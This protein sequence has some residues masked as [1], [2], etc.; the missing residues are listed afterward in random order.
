MT[1]SHWSG[2]RE[3]TAARIALG[4]AGTSLPTPALLRFQ[5]DHAR[6]R[7]AV[8]GS[9]DWDD[10]ARRLSAPAAKRADSERADSERADP[11]RADSRCAEIENAADV[12]LRLK[13]QAASRQI[14][15]QRPDL[16]RRLAPDSAAL[17]APAATA[18]DRPDLVFVLCDGLSARA[19]ERQAVDFVRR[20]LSLARRRGW[21]VGPVCLVEQGR[22]AL[23][24]PI[25][26]AL[27]ARLVVVLI[28]ERPGLS[29]PDSLGLY[30][31]Y[32]PRSG[33]TDERRNC[34]SNIRPAGLPVDDAVQK[35]DYLASQALVRQ[36]SGVTLK[37]EWNAKHEKL[38]G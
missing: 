31:T 5:L 26:E 1:D 34:I 7:D 3:F 36:L 27:R 21:S 9:P 38:L 2:L 35:F 11:G 15:L 16:G 32:G 23:G 10:V 37:D 17:F 28:G 14:Y 6:A 8:Y 29:S 4:R 22:V 33:T 24:D 30:M 13:S 25:G 18:S 19:I 12:V 20:A